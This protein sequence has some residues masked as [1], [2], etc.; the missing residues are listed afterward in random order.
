[1]AA[2]LPAAG[3]RSAS[4]VRLALFITFLVRGTAF[5][6]PLLA[7]QVHGLGY[8]PS[9][10]G[11][12]LA[13]FGFGWLVGQPVVGWLADRYGARGALV[14]ALAVGAVG[15]PLAGSARSPL[16]LAAGA[17][18]AGAVFDSPRP[19][20]SAVIANVLPHKADRARAASWRH[21]VVNVGAVAT[22]AAG[23]LLAGGIGLPALWRV[24]G[25]GCALALV[26]AVWLPACGRPGT[27]GRD[28]LAAAGDRRLWWLAGASLG[29]F[30]PVM[31]LF[32]VLPLLMA[33][34]R[35]PPSAFGVVQVA[36]GIAVLALTP[37]L[38]V[39]LSRTAARRPLTGALA[40]GCVALGA[41]MGCVGFAHTTLGY[42]AAAVAATPGEII[43]FIAAGDV[44]ARVAPAHLQGAYAGVW[45]TT[46][47]L[48]DILAP[49]TA[50]RALTAGGPH[51][52]GLLLCA[53]GVL[54]AVLCPPLSRRLRKHRKPRS[55]TALCAAASSPV[56]AGCEAS[57]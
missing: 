29:A 55:A 40:G 51:L 56:P 41:S 8:G 6:Y 53:C 39:W 44:L 22:G 46:L 32:A 54:G 2:E 35:L 48:A 10:T 47:A 42:T 33:D 45:G 26:A 3:R 7:Y 12:V 24:E 5:S 15:I 57:S 34:D 27:S 23:G 50:S 17:V 28:L 38:G 49:L 19:A 1:M 25:I 16:A 31:A 18:L 11:T 37:L 52:V 9:A 36:N 4:A 20:T 30:I 43:A 13:C 21:W 14:S